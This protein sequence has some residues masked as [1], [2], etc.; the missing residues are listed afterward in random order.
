MTDN[1]GETTE[2]IPTYL[3]HSYRSEDRELNYY[4]WKLLWEAGFLVQVDKRSDDPRAKVF[5][6]PYLELMMQRSTCFV[7]VIPLRQE[8]IRDLCSPYI[9]WEYGLAVQSKKPR[10]IFVEE[11][12]TGRYF[13]KDKPGVQTF[14]RRNL[15]ARESYYEKELAQLAR[16]SLPYLQETLLLLGKVGLILSADGAPN[17]VYSKRTIDEISKIVEDSGREPVI[18]SPSFRRNF[19]FALKL[20]ECDFLIVDI[21]PGSLP[22]WL[23][24]YVHGRSAPA[25]KLLH[26]PEVIPGA[27][28]PQL[29]SGQL[30]RGAGTEPDSVVFWRDQA[31]LLAEINTQLEKFAI[32]REPFY[33][34][35]T[36][37][38]YFLGLGLQKKKI[39]ISNAR[40]TNGL[41]QRISDQLKRWDVAHFQ[42][43][44]ENLLPVGEEWDIEKLEREIRTSDIFV[45]LLTKDYFES[46]YCKRENETALALHKDKKIQFIPYFLEQGL[47]SH[48]IQGENLASKKPDE[49]LT[50]IQS[51]LEHILIGEQVPKTATSDEESRKIYVPEEGAIDIGIV[52]ILQEEYEAVLKAFDR[53]TRPVPRKGQPDLYGWMIGE[54]DSPGH[55]RP[56]RV[57][58]AY[59]GRPRNVSGALATQRTIDQWKPRYILMIGIGGGL[60]LNNLALGDV[61]VSSMI[62]AY[63]YGKVSDDKFT[64][65][66][67]FTYPVDNGLLR[68]AGA[69]AMRDSSWAEASRGRFPELSAAP[70]VV[71]GP[72]ASGDKV[73][74]DASSAF[75]HQ[76]LTHWPKLQAIEMEGGGAADAIAEANS[77]GRSVGFIMIRGISDMPPIEAQET[78]AQTPEQQSMER[79]LWKQVAAE[80][81]AAFTIHF[82]RKGWPEAPAQADI[83]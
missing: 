45:A 13:P 71:I 6:I 43:V 44:E 51:S 72:V 2:K 64:P 82:I 47:Q 77:A 39:F 50:W 29:I 19:E 55:K 12:V 7:A 4:F 68:C 38:R 57:V 28:I 76:V 10:V 34:F 8:E 46:D 23:F 73:I 70:K 48:P 61:V 24:P 33:D 78:G 42:Y 83:K 58:L 20:D 36:G 31:E 67:D 52:T 9:L 75:F 69:L 18:I 74:D 15:K 54:V 56:F 49:Q 25:I 27:A 14:D 3:S 53:S 5:S 80:S 40:S 79:N 16:K 59:G 65:R 35:E 41:A 63:E 21:T 37:E 66:P 62:W 17:D 81:A 60:P 26:L 32:K 11:D 30:V 1:R 22:D